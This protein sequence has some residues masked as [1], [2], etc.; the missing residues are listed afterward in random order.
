MKTKI[1]LY[2]LAIC[3]AATACKKETITSEETVVSSSSPYQQQLAELE[4]LI[5][6]NV[7]VIPMFESII[8]KDFPIFFPDTIIT[9]TDCK[10]QQCSA[11]VPNY[12]RQ[13]QRT[14]NQFCQPMNIH[15][16]CCAKNYEWCFRFKIHPQ[17]T[18]APLEEDKFLQP[19]EGIPTEPN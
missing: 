8:N 11:V 14:A 13:M 16:C 1:F 3:L 10:E 18:C 5:P 2:C 7:E 6:D 9:L 19:V 17:F 4:L 15:I 12:I